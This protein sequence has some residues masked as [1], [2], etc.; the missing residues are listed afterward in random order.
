LGILYASLTAFLWGFLAIALKVALNFVGPHAIV[1]VRFIIAFTILLL[2]FSFRNPGFLKILKRPPIILLV[3]AFCLGLNYIGFMQGIRYT[4]PGNTQI[5]IQL[6]PVLLAIVG[7]IIYKEKLS[8]RQMSGFAIAGIGFVVFYYNQ[9][10]N[11]LKDEDSFNIGVLYTLSG[12]VC[13]VIYAAFQK[14]LVQTWPAQQLNLVIYG[15]PVLMFFPY[16]EFSS[17]EGLHFGHWLLL[18]FLGINTL[19]AYGSLTVAFKYLEANKVSI[20]I[21][22]NPIITFIAMSVLD[23][24][25]VNWIKPEVINIYGYMGALMVLSGAVL[26]VKKSGNKASINPSPRSYNT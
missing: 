24:L 14:K 7:V 1:W 11:F 12:A 9:L 2:F 19:V 26:A 21:T 23:R 5:I 8:L 3:A 10:A 18:I 4:S 15:L 25:N 17:L 6:G 20:I 16:V 13:W 22:L